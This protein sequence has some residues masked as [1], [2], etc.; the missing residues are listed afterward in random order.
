MPL[1]Q[2]SGSGLIEF[3]AAVEMAVDQGMNGSEFL[4]GLDVSET[5]H[6]LFFRRP[7]S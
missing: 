3:V 2:G 1:G 7:Y 4:Q 5:R 6:R